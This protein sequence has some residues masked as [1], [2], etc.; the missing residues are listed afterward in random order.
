[1]GVPVKIA[2]SVLKIAQRRSSSRTTL[3]DYLVDTD[4][5]NEHLANN[6]QYLLYNRFICSTMSILAGVLRE[7]EH[8]RENKSTAELSRANTAEY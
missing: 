3:P 5:D 2:Q 4:L 6:P 7:Y 1:M 8:I